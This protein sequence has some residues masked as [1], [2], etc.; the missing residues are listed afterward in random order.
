MLRPRSFR[1][2]VSVAFFCL[3]ARS[4]LWA[5]ELT[6]DLDPAN[7]K[8]EFTLADV[9]HTVHGNFAL[10]SGMIHFNPSAHSASGLVVVDVKSGQSG[11]TMRDRKMHKEILQSEQYPDAT[12][13]PTRMSGTFA[14]QGSSSIQV[15]GIFR[16]HGGD[17]AI[18]LVIPLEVSGT[19]VSFKTQ[20]AIPYAQWGMKNP[21]TFLLKV[22][23]KVDLDIAAT[24]HLTQAH[25]P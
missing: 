7:T 3:A 20:L 8:I 10:S 13:V 5:Q 23:D 2:I 12:F 17:H 15:D 1:L 6:L 22:S 21:S 4:G 24:G 9:L 18:T 16:I 11:N 19:S 14:A 25:Q